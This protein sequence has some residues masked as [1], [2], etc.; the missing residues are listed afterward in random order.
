MG[1][2]NRIASIQ[3]RI[4]SDLTSAMTTAGVPVNAGLRMP[5]T[6]GLYD[7]ASWLALHSRKQ[8]AP[9]LPAAL[10]GR[11]AGIDVA[12][13]GSPQED[14]AGLSYGLRL[15]THEFELHLW[16]QC[17]DIQEGAGAYDESTVATFQGTIASALRSDPQLGGYCQDSEPAVVVLTE[18]TRMAG[19]GCIHT[20]SRLRCRERIV[21]VP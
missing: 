5:G 10:V 19:Q 8:I 11:V 17:L 16:W 7:E 12:Y 3:G 4:V 6:E 2:Q 13:T 18:R 20:V 15:R 14:Y 21:L 1:W 9:P